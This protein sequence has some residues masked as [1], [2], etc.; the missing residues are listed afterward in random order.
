MRILLIITLAV[1][2]CG[3]S[4]KVDYYTL[5]MESSGRAESEVN[6]VV[7]R[8]HTTE[9]LGRSRIMIAASETRV[10]YY[11]TANWASSVSE[12]VQRKLQSEFGEP[13]DADRKFLLS[14]RI[15]AF[16]QVDAGGSSSARLAIEAVIRDPT[17]KRYDEPLLT[18]TFSA[19]KPVAAADPDAV[20]AAL[21]VCA[22]DVAADIAAAIAGL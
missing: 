9:A 10:E 6:V 7:E 18:A 8:M 19:T 20:A 14:G 22:E 15:T 4:P 3:S 17:L 5:A 12:L 11:A 13:R 2:G 1:A 21:S 16:E